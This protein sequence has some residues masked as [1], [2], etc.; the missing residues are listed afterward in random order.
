[1]GMMV[2]A[3]DVIAYVLSVV[4]DISNTENLREAMSIVQHVGLLRTV[5]FDENGDM[6]VDHELYRYD[7]GEFV[8]FDL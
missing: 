4:D 8:K 5:T 2:D 6:R 3:V 7:Q 1:M